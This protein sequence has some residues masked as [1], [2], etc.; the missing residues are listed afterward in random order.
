MDEPWNW[1]CQLGMVAHLPASANLQATEPNCKLWRIGLWATQEVPWHPTYGARKYT[2]GNTI[3]MPRTNHTSHLSISLEEYKSAFGDDTVTM[4][5][6]R[7]CNRCGFETCRLDTLKAHALRKVTCAPTKSDIPI[8]QIRAEL[9]CTPAPKHVCPVCGETRDSKQAMAYHVGH[10][11][12]YKEPSM[13]SVKKAALH[14][15]SQIAQQAEHFLLVSVYR[16]MFENAPNSSLVMI[17]TLDSR[18]SLRCLDKGSV[19]TLPAAHVLLGAL[20]KPMARLA[21][22]MQSKG[23]RLPLVLQCEPESKH[24]QACLAQV[25]VFIQLQAGRKAGCMEQLLV[26][27]MV[28][29][30]ASNP[31]MNGAAWKG[32]WEL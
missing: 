25:A 20:R 15:L 29:S 13:T 4:P 27:E 32:D 1:P 6:I 3:T 24:L 2:W 11:H 7:T 18:S 31:F 21:S 14:T 10:T 23:M 17:D 5:C 8:E 16:C 22:Y 9:G 30:A 26:D 19:V 12:H 28:W